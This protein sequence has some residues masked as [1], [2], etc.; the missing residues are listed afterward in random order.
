MLETYEAAKAFM[1][2]LAR[3]Q[4]ELDQGMFELLVEG[5][6]DKIQLTWKKVHLE[7]QEQPMAWPESDVLRF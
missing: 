6:A 2:L 1:K 4:A 7:L 5:A 3:P